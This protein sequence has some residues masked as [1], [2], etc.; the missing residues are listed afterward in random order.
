MRGNAI[1]AG[2]RESSEPAPWYQVVAKGKR[3]GQTA[4]Q[5]ENLAKARAA[6]RAKAR[7]AEVENDS[8]G[9][10]EARD[11]VATATEAEGSEGLDRGCSD[12]AL[13]QDLRMYDASAED[14][15]V[16]PGVVAI[17]VGDAKQF[18][19]GEG[20]LELQCEFRQCFSDFAVAFPF[21]FWIV[22]AES[23]ARANHFFL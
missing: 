3:G 21:G 9:R 22:E 18:Q 2:C 15:E 17:V 6:K 5:A 1:T 23:G 19:H 10:T 7:G 8:G 20:Q 13:G 14:A 16:A 11:L 12:V 4:K